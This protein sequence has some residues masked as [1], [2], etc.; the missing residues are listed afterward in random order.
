M[1]QNH[2]VNRGPGGSDR[3]RLT[4]VLL[5]PLMTFSTR[6]VAVPVNPNGESLAMKPEGEKWPLKS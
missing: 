2:S 5:A 6:T 3:A 1:P 4:T